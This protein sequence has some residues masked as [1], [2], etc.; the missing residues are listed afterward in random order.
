MEDLVPV[1]RVQSWISSRNGNKLKAA[2]QF[3]F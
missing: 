2:A 3:V 1:N